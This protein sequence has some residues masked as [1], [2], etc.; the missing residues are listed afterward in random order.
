M[1]K[2]VKKRHVLQMT[3]IEKDY[4]NSIIRPQIRKQFNKHKPLSEH[5][6]DRLQSKFDI[7]PTVYDIEDVLFNGNIIEYKE[8]YTNNKLTDKRIVV[9]KGIH[10]NKYD[11]VLVYSV[12]WNNVITV[13]KNELTDNHRTLDLRLYDKNP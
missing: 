13:W 1:K 10:N 6:L 5:T 4:L 8:I 3:D 11:L 2:V 7:V 9:R 12:K